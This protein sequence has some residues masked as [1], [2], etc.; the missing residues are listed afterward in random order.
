[1]NS[2]KYLEN[3]YSNC[4]VYRMNLDVSESTARYFKYWEKLNQY[5]KRRRKTKKYQ[6]KRLHIKNEKFTKVENQQ[7]TY[8]K[9]D[10]TQNNNNNNNDGF[11]DNNSGN[12]ILLN[13]KVSQQY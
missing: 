6:L 2:K 7:F 9:K 10:N 11:N 3:V 1:L 4:V 13:N 12:G 5:N 8:K